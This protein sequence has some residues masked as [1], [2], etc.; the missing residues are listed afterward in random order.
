MKRRFSSYAQ[1]QGIEKIREGK[2]AS[3]QVFPFGDVRRAQY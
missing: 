3:E 1:S 2:I